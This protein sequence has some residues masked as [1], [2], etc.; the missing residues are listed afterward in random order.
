M[1]VTAGIVITRTPQTRRRHGRE[2]GRSARWN[3]SCSIA[4]SPS[5]RRPSRRDEPDLALLPLPAPPPRR[6]SVPSNEPCPRTSPRALLASRPLNPQCSTFSATP[7]IGEG[8][9]HKIRLHCALAPALAYAQKPPPPPA[10]P[11][12][13]PIA[14]LPDAGRNYINIGR[15]HLVWASTEPDGRARVGGRPRATWVHAGNLELVFDG[16]VDPYFKGQAN[17]ILRSRPTARRRRV[18]RRSSRRRRPG[19]LGSRSGNI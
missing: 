19:K 2:S 16:A 18:R 10:P 8:L 9:I 5:G 6:L 3:G 15:R 1:T 4:D 17:V 11:E 13:P 12:A 14:L 7:R